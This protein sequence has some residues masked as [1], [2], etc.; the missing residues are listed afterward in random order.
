MSENPLDGGEGA[1]L[2]VANASGQH[3]LWRLHLA[4]PNGWRIVYSGLH[5]D[6]ALDYVERNFTATVESLTP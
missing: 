2:V 4:V 6:G 1:W 3:A 5:R